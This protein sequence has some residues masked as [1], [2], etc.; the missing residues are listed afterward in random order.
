MFFD[1]RF[2]IDWLSEAQCQLFHSSHH[3]LLTKSQWNS[4]IHRLIVKSSFDINLLTRL[5]YSVS[6]FWLDLILI[7]NWYQI[8]I[9]NLTHQ[10]IENDVKRTKYRNFSD[11]SSLHYL[12]ALPFCITFLI[13][14]HKEKH[15]GKHEGYLIES[16]N[17]V[18]IKHLSIYLHVLTNWV[19]NFESILDFNSLTWLKYSSQTSQ[20]NLNTQVKNSDSNWVLTSRILDLNSNIQLDAISLIIHLSSMNSSI[21]WHQWRVSAA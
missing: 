18:I 17:R 15:E 2:L 11:F 14:S 9:L 16:H 4:I 19:G 5:E 13:E 6:T 3:F 20:L 21:L 10:E 1:E 12:F 8:R 7:S